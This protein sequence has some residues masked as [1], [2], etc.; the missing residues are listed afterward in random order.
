PAADHHPGPGADPAGGAADRHRVVSQGAHP[1]RVLL[2]S[3]PFG[4]LE[5]PSLSLGLLQAHC[6]RLGVR[7]DTRYLT[8]AYADRVG[9]GDYLWAC[10]DDLP[11]TAFAGE[12]LFA[13]ALYG[14]RPYADAAY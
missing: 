12:W 13:Q 5:R 2:I 4:A 1:E 7:C 14:M 6:H 10:S 11:Y 8:F 9:L 3:M